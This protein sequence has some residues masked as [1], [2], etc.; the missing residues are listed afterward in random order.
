[1]IPGVLLNANRLH[2]YATEILIQ[3]HGTFMLKGPWF[4]NMDLVLTTDPL[5]IHH[6]LSKNFSNYPKGDKYRQIFDILGDGIL[7]SDGKRRSAA[8]IMETTVWNKVENGLLPILESICERGTEID[9]Q[10]ICQRFTFDNVC[11]LLTDNDPESLSLDF[12]Y[13]PCI[14]ALTDAEEAVSFRHVTLPSL[15]NLQR[16]LRMGKEKK[17]SDAWETIDQFVYKYLYQ[18][19]EEYNNMNHGAEKF[20]FYTAIMKELTDQSDNS[21]DTKKILRDT[22][23]NLMFAGKGT[24]SSA[25]CWFFYLLARNPAIEDKI[26]EEIYTHLEV[27]AHK[28]WNTKEL[29]KMVYLHGALCESLRLYPPIPFNN[30]SPLQPEIL[31]SGHHVDPN[32]NII[33]CFY[34][35]GRM[36]SICGE[37][38]MEFKPERWISNG[39]GIKHVPSYKFSTFNAGPRACVGKNM[40]FSQLKIIT[41]MIIY[42]YHIQLVE[43]HPV[44]PADSVVLQMKHG[45][46]FTGHF[47]LVRIDR[48]SSRLLLGQKNLHVKWWL[49][50][51]EFVGDEKLKS[52]HESRKTWTIHMEFVTL[53]KT[54]N[55]A[56]RSKETK[57]HN[58]FG[59]WPI[60]PVTLY[61]RLGLAG[62]VEVTEARVLFSVTGMSCS[63][64]AGSVE[65]A[66][67]R[68][69]GIKEAV[70]DVCTCRDN[71]AARLNGKLVAIHKKQRSVIPTNW[72]ILGMTPAILVNAHRFLDFTA[73]IL[74]QSGGTV[75]LKGPWFANLDM[76]LTTDPLDIH[77]ILSK[78]FNNY[79]KG[80]K[81]RKIFYSLGDGILNSDGEIW[82]MNRKIIFS[83][84]KQPGFQTMMETTMWNKVE[85]GLLPILDSIC[86]RGSEIDFQDIFQRFAFDSV[87][88]L[89]LDNDPKSLSLSFPYIPSFQ[90]FADAEEAI[91]LRH[92]TPPYLWKLQQILKV[93]TEKRFSDA[94]KNVDELIHKCLAQ[95][96]ECNNIEK[97][98]FSTAIMSELTNQSGTSLDPTKFL[99]DTIHN[100][101][102][103]GKDTVGSALCWFFY[104]LATN[105]TVEDKILEEIHMHLE[106]GSYKRWNTTD[107][108][109]M[110]YLHGALCESLRLY[111]PVPFN[112]KTPLQPEMLPSGHQVNRNTKIILS[113]YSMGRMESIWGEDCMEFKPER[114]ISNNGGI[115][116]EPSYKFTTFN[117]GPRACLGKNM[118]FS[119]LKM[120]ITSIIYHYHIQ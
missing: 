106:V 100:L 31:P 68:L 98:L 85:N 3:S 111:P 87:C 64:C 45:L 105:P 16:I 54:M 4:A 20:L 95:I 70:V 9:L 7:N 34:S 22:T 43:G 24:V 30:K 48:G 82:E 120:V 13:M 118:A 112:H 86:R 93:G 119:Q 102:A 116:N 39:G 1:M 67:K 2:D 59:P 29:D 90:A 78:N 10:D 47:G 19:Q 52:L 46:K 80:D 110:I 97:F 77:H 88:I 56:L 17:L 32:T 41:P 96:K 113:F 62:S 71:I 115:K 33:L 21:L 49:L 25:L 35:M 108:D 69:P 99:K 84:F 65:K 114:W 103:A 44:V 92:L 50:L 12:P 117:A 8:S 53:S 38:C 28:R 101:M 18:K 74:I 73:E 76:L 14:K 5:D 55:D 107:L 109:K 57:V 94:K 37:D 75:I 60:E 89:L 63:A 51:T 15:W 36:K 66:V 104:L 23:V 6:I 61:R 91:L 81:F 42:R 26:L 11:K 40:T 27:N 79:P 58:S 72:P 83:V